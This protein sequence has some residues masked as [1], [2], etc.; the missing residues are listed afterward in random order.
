MNNGLQ[1]FCLNCSKD[2][3]KT[4]FNVED[5][6]R[7]IAAETTTSILVFYD[8]CRSKVD[9]DPGFTRNGFINKKFAE[10]YEYI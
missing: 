7:I 5:K 9:S 8:C 4:T 3:E 2:E 10:K 1:E 6:L